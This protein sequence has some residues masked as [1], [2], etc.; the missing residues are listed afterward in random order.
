MKNRFESRRAIFASIGLFALLTT[1][2]ANAQWEFVYGDETSSENGGRG[3]QALQVCD[4]SGFVTVGTSTPDADVRV[5]RTDA[6]GI[7]V[8]EHVYDIGAG[9]VDYGQSIVELRDGSGF[10]ITGYTT[11]HAPLRNVFLLK[12]SCDGDFEWASVFHAPRNEVGYD[13]V[14]AR[15]GN[16]VFGTAEGDLIVVG[17]Y[18]NAFGSSDGLILRA[19]SGGSLIWARSYDLHGGREVFRGVIQSRFTATGSPTGDIVA[20]GRHQGPNDVDALVVR[21]S[22]D[23]GEFTVPSHCA[24]TYGNQFQEEFNAVV[25]LELSGL[26]GQLAFAGSTRVTATSPANIYVA[27]SQANPCQDIEHRRFGDPGDDPLAD[28][29]AT[30]ILEQHVPLN[31]AGIGSLLIT[32]GA[33]RIGTQAYDAFLL[34]VRPTFLLEVPGS[35]RLFGD[36]AG[37]YEAGVSLDEVAASMTAPAGVVIDATSRSDFEGNGDPSDSYLIRTDSNGATGCTALYDPEEFDTP[38]DAE[39]VRIDPIAVLQS[40]PVIDVPFDREETAFNVC[41]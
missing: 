17:M 22:G 20:V 9:S 4:R 36:H 34:A 35:G 7:P 10:V 2:E 28:E 31:F 41:P 19:D 18:S 37:R 38:Y 32:G 39:M 15:S 27:Q 30:D 25:E 26:L 29:F 11:H 1:T 16:P 6:D 24:A 12:I 14:E 21:V 33:G 3:V 40:E 8:F 13:V 5:V 23:N